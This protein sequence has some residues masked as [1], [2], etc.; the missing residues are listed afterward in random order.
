[1]RNG[2]LKLKKIGIPVNTIIDVGAAAGTWTT[3]AR[4]IWPECSYLLFEPL[5][6]RQPV[7]SKLSNDH[8]G[9]YFFPFAA[10]KEDGEAKLYVADDLDGSGVSSDPDN[11]DKTRVVKQT[12]INAA[13]GELDLKGPYIIKLDTHGYEVPILEGCSAIIKDVSALIIECYGFRIAKNSLLFDQMCR[14]VDDLGFRL[15]DIVDIMHRPLD[16][17]LWQCDAFFIRKDHPVYATPGYR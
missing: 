14:Y 16:D 4:A 11:S 15:Y 5:E 17:A 3:I 9:I 1:M 10:G 8:P 6:E 2:L 12:S 13:I 7:L